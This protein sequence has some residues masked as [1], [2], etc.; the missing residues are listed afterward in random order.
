MC[1]TNALMSINNEYPSQSSLKEM[2]DHIENYFPDGG[3]CNAASNHDIPRS[4]TRMT[5]TQAEQYKGI[6]KR[7]LMKLFIT[8]PG[9]FC[10]YQGEELG[11][12]QASIP[13]D[14]PHDKL[15]DEVAFTKGLDH[16]RDGART[17]MPW[18][19]LEKNAGFSDSDHP[20]LPIPD[21]HQSEAVNLQDADP[22]SVLNFTRHLLNWRK[23]Q[24]A[25]ISGKT[26][27]LSTNDPILAFTRESD[28]QVILCMFNLSEKSAT[29]T[30]SDY[31]DD[32]RLK[33]F[34]LLKG[35]KVILGAFGS[36]VL[37]ANPTAVNNNATNTQLSGTAEH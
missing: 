21:L 22:A 15:K 11:L 31:I 10:L 3:N 17:P 19:S 37:G 1:Y 14:I 18:N 30:L 25:L 26:S 4:G 20:Y 32:K 7:Q 27:T 9:S 24:P 34:G 33:A 6:I 8:L 5:A 16:S 2:I 36:K 35:Q 13:D 12:D 28:E 23:S 29:V